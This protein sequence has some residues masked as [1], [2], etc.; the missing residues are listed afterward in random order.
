SK[1]VRAEDTFERRRVFFEEAFS[2]VRNH[3]RAPQLG[4][5]QQRPIDE[6]QTHR[7]GETQLR[8]KRRV[9]VVYAQSAVIEPSLSRICENTEISRQR[10]A[11]Q[12]SGMAVTGVRLSTA[13]RQRHLCPDR[14]RGR[15]TVLTEQAQV[16]AESQV[17]D[18]HAV[19]RRVPNPTKL[20]GG[21]VLMK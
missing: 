2:V 18:L 4:A 7:R 1:V 20:D 16:R 17:R 10:R 3:R 21:A 13:G 5:E 19:P 11:R 8:S 9:R 12:E 14:Q 15:V 6:A